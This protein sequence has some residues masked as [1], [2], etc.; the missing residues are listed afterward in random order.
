M[1]GH[2]NKL[3]AYELGLPESTVSET[4]RSAAKKLGT[5]SR[6][7]LVRML[8]SRRTLDP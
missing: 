6:L 5:R 7:D 1:L 2:A 4:L 8:A 3:I